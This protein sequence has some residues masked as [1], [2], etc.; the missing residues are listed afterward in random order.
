MDR[1]RVE[2]YAL[3]PEIHEQVLFS[4][5][6]MLYWEPFGRRRAN[7]SGMGRSVAGV[8]ITKTIGGSMLESGLKL[9][10]RLVGYKSF[11][12]W[13]VPRLLPLSYTFSLTFRCDSRCLTCN[14]WQKADKKNELSLAEWTKIFRSLGSAP[15]W[16]TLTGGNQFLRSD[17]VQLC[18]AIVEI[19]RPAIIN[20]P[21]SGSLPELVREKVEQILA[22]CRKGGTTLISNISL[23]GLGEQQDRLRGSR[24]NFSNTLQT[25]RELRKLR[26]RF[27]NFFIGVYSIISRHNLEQAGPLFDYVLDEL[28]PDDYSIE[29][30]EYRHE[31]ENVEGEFLPSAREFLPVLELFLRKRRAAAKGLIGLRETIRSSYFSTLEQVLRQRREIVPCYA[32]IASS[33][34]SA[35]GQVWECCTRAD[36]LGN[37]RDYDYDFPRLFHSARAD[38][39]RKKI[40]QEHC[41]CTHSNPC[42]TSMLC[43]F[44]LMGKIAWQ[45][46]SR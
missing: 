3:A 21:T 33:Q 29:I 23:D 19:N 18:R 27:P 14:V 17:L 34:V 45:V 41:F 20:I 11:R 25:Y 35:T 30:A 36:V 40:K 13:G 38:T 8:F 28:R 15:H 43:N 2:P 31:L 5:G 26:E 42:Y 32:G 24:D 4:A 12:Q 6:F 1:Q 7:G 22:V 9:L 44:K 16:I 39:V 46:I 37:L 10:P